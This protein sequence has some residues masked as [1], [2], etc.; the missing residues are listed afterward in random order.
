M[1]IDD[2]RHLNE[3]VHDL[4]K[5]GTV[6]VDMDMCIVCVAGD[7]RSCNSGFE[8]LITG[9]LKEIPIRMISYGGSDHNISFVIKKED[10]DAALQALSNEIFK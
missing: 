10:R 2:T 9:A 4:K 7:L 6:N 1:S 5:F 8:S 3:I